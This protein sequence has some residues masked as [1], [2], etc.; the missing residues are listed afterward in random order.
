MTT[1]AICV[2]GTSETH[3]ASGTLPPTGMTKLVTD[4]LP[5]SIK[6]F[7]VPYTAGYGDKASYLN[8]VNNGKANLR[9]ILSMLNP[10]DTVY[11][12]CYSQGCTIGGDIVRDVALGSIP[13]PKIVAY[14]GISDPRRN[15]SDITGTDPGGAGITGERGPWPKTM[16]TKVY[17]F[18]APGDIIASSEPDK[19][20]FLD[21]SKFT[22]HFWVGDTMGWV[23]YCIAVLN[24][25]AF[26][27][28][29]RTEYGFKGIG[30]WL[31]FS[32]RARRTIELGTQYLI[33]QVHVKYGS[34]RV[35]GKY[36]PY[37][38]ADDIIGKTQETSN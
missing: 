25:S 4:K 26:Q 36:L 30:G 14:Y 33:S 24:S 32:K 2:P 27:K 7:S 20:L 29:L 10:S 17:Q 11:L 1:Y 6:S 19:D 5:T 22:N 18:C 12:I 31:E 3:D 16:T 21:I 9:K 34:Y 23:A 38:I 28:Q 8:S 37:W 15:H 13:S 35:N